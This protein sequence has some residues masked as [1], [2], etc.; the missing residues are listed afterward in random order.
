VWS[1]SR[2]AGMLALRGYLLV[3]AV[4][5]VVKVVQLALGQ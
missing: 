5:L 2:K 1:T 4:L 3:A